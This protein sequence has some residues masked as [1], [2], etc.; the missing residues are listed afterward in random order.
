MIKLKIVKQ[1]IGKG[2]PLPY[3]IY[4]KMYQQ[5]RELVLKWIWK[6]WRRLRFR[7]L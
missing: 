3:E 2:K 6:C 7:K 4:I 5:N 1:V